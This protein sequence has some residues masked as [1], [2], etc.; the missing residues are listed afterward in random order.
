MN[1]GLPIRVISG[2]EHHSSYSPNR[3]YTYAGLYK[4]VDAWREE[5]KSGYQICRF[6]LVYIGENAPDETSEQIEI[7]FSSDGG[8]TR[9]SQTTVDRI[10]R[11]TR[12][13]QEI[14]SLY[15]NACQ[16]CGTKI[17]TKNGFYS[18]G[19]HI[20][21]LGEPHNGEDSLDNLLCLCPNHHVM[22]DRGAFSISD[23]F[24]LIGVENKE[25]LMHHDHDINKANLAYHRNCFEFD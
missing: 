9:R 7:D 2:H 23:D 3:G 17:P 4:V 20:R 8:G 1:E 5:G 10:I 6:H 18:E 24:K 16:I 12:L 11:N 22:L 21:P 13:T 14:K 19:A 25:L 15:D